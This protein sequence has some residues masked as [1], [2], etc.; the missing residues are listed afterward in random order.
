[1]IRWQWHGDELPITPVECDEKP[2]E[3]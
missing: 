3:E 2:T 1:V